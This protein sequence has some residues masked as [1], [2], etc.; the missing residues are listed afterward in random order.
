M[1][2]I[3]KSIDA[4]PVEDVQEPI[5]TQEEEPAVKPKAKRAPRVKK[6]AVVEP[7]IEEQTTTINQ[8]VAKVALLVEDI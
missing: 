2:E 5:T 6:E 8:I 1:T 3:A 7:L 4:E